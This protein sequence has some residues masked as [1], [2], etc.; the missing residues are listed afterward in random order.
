MLTIMVSSRIRKLANARAAT[1]MASLAPV[2]SS[3]VDFESLFSDDSTLVSV[4]G[5][6]AASPPGIELGSESD[7]GADKEAD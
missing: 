4:P 7:A 3:G 5:C 6:R 1:M 2:T